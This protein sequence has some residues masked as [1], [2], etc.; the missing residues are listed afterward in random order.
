MK[1]IFR[2][3][4]LSLAALASLAN[5]AA[6]QDIVVKTA[7]GGGLDTNAPMIHVDIFYDYAANQMQA[8][9][10]TS[11]GVPKLLPLPPG[12]TFDSRSNYYVLN[13]KA[14]NYQYA[15]N[16]GG[17]FTNPPGAAVWV[18]CISSSAGLET[19]DGPG[20]KM[21]SI[22]RTY[23]PIFGTGSSS[24]RWQWYGSMAHNSYAVLNPSNPVMSAT[25]R[26]YFGDAQTGAPEAYENYGDATVTLTWDV[27]PVVVVKTARGGGLDTNAPMIHVDILYDYDA[28]QMR[29]TLDTSKGIPKLVPLP[30]GYTFDSRSNYAVLNGKAYNYQ[31]AWNPGGIFTNPPGAAVW[32]ECISASP[33]LETYDGPGNKMLTVPRNYAPIFGTAGS[34]P[35]WQWYGSM[36]HN[37]YAVLNP[38]NSVMSATYRIYFGDAQTGSREAY[39]GYGDATMTLTWTVDPPMFLFGAEASTDGTPLCLLNS[40][41]FV[42]NAQP[43][44]NLRYTGSGPCAGTYELPLQFMSVPGTAVNGGPMTNHAALGSQLHLQLV[45]LAGPPDATLAFWDAGQSQP[46]FRIST[47]RNDCTDCIAVSQTNTPAGGDPFG[48]LTGRHVALSHPGLYT[49]GFRAIDVSTNGPG[50]GPIHKPSPVYQVYLQAGLTISALARQSTYATALF[51]GE[52]GK[53]YYLESSTTPAPAAS[54][55]T[56]AGPLT[57]DARLQTLSG[58]ATEPGPRFFRLRASTP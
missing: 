4:V 15:W 33:G 29:A 1:A 10:D 28:N 17:I 30:N 27:D 3:F 42:N 45:S 31:Y 22:P 6:A 46:A 35:R 24:T 44:V 26:I 9:L 53:S 39:A 47:G 2:F 49:L 18:E 32:I 13:G 51:G 41:Q 5:P 52:P 37:S 20:N 21:L 58:S 34:S 54:W 50:G 19:Y 25:Y 40:Q 14:Y 12:Y 56:V 23:A 16:P 55:Q 43:V 57:G 7:R 36:A 38:S 11:K 48:M 8:T